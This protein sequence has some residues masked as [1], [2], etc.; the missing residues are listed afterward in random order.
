MSNYNIPNIANT[1]HIFQLLTK[2]KKTLNAS[3]IAKELELPRTSVYRILKTL[4]SENMVRKVGKGYVMGH[5][6]IN[7]GLQV[8]SKIPERQICVP[9]LQQLT[10]QIHESTH[11]A[12]LS[13]RNMLL[14]EVCDSPHALKVASRPGTLADIH[15]SA[16]GKCFLAHA[17][18]AAA[19]ALMD[20]LD[21]T[22]RTDKTHTTKESLKEELPS[23]K[24]KGYAVDDIEYNY[25]IRCLAAPVFNASGQIVGAIGT[26]AAT[27]RFPKSRIAEIAKEV[28]HAANKLSNEFGKNIKPQNHLN[29]V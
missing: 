28:I 10:T 2:S 4:E 27:S 23:I 3:E 20:S 1:C 6:L 19:E 16:S 5:R 21:Y 22:K 26:T 13:G 12:I 15:C 18:E 14:I 17:P 9:I 11:F 25:H 24:R 7:L 8:V 29:H